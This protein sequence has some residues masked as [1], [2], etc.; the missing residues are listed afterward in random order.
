MAEYIL[1][2]QGDYR[3]ISLDMPGWED[4]LQNAIAL[5][6]AFCDWVIR[7]CSK[8]GLFQ[9]ANFHSQESEACYKRMKTQ[10]SSLAGSDKAE[11]RGLLSFICNLL[12]S[13]SV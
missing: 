13:L 9:N 10:V 1:V 7:Q 6:A 8:D 2:D 12:L 3:F 4:A 11:F 5:S